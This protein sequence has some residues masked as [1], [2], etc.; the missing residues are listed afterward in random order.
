M[1]L[2]SVVRALKEQQNDSSF[3]GLRLV[4]L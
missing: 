4:L 2:A 1:K 3:V